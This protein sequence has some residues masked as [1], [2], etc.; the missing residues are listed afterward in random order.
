MSD[1]PDDLNGIPEPDEAFNSWG[2]AAVGIDPLLASMTNE[3]FAPVRP[4]VP[5]Y[6]F[7]HYPDVLDLRHA[8]YS[9]DRFIPVFDTLDDAR[10]SQA[11]LIHQLLH[12]HGENPNPIWN[13]RRAREVEFSVR[14]ALH[15]F[16]LSDLPTLLRRFIG[17]AFPDESVSHLSIDLMN[18]FFWAALAEVARDYS[19]R[20][21]K[22]AG[23]ADYLSYPVRMIFRL[24]AKAAAA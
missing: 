11:I 9:V 2:A 7:F 15:R 14:A 5:F 19:W 12:L 18:V 17:R 3:P 1:A 8:G 20:E 23:Y 13:P 24:D 4:H 10:Y 6:R 16:G 22:L 21:P